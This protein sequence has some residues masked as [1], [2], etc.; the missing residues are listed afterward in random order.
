[1]QKK[2]TSLYETDFNTNL[3]YSQTMFITLKA[4]YY[5]DHSKQIF[6]SVFED[7]IFFFCSLLHLLGCM[8][9][10]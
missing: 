7:A 5:I 1:M 8:E 10:N 4:K 6:Q 2:Y 3:K 9:S